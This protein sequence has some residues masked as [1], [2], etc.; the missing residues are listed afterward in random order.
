MVA[1]SISINSYI[2][3]RQFLEGAALA[4][5]A[6][7]ELVE[8]QVQSGIVYSPR[9]AFVGADGV[10]RQFISAAAAAP[11][12]YTVGEKMEVRYRLENPGSAE[13]DNWS[14]LWLRSVST[15]TLAFILILIGGITYWMQNG[16]ETIL[17]E[18][19]TFK[20]VG[21]AFAALGPVALLGGLVQLYLDAE[22]VSQSTSGSGRVER[23]AEVRSTGSS[24][25][26]YYPV[27]SFQANGRTV[28]FVSSLG[29]YPARYRPG[30]ILQIRYRENFP[31]R[32]RIDGFINV[33]SNSIVILSIGTVFSLVGGLLLRLT[34]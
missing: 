31:E 6:V 23:L 32:A 30:E 24:S 26:S 1:L 18:A 21:T 28:H 11:A 12:T 20:I 8:L 25:F 33:W 10:P 2:K 27:I 29:D 19:D 3:T 16:G 13:I 15:G 17:A 4:N 34:A 5:G 9:V 22:F 14:S 7:T